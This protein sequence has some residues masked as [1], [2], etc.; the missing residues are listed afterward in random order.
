MGDVHTVRGLSILQ[1][2]Y[3]GKHIMA[4]S[5]SLRWVS[6]HGYTRKDGVKVRP[7][8][9]GIIRVYCFLKEKLARVK[10]G[11]SK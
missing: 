2:C 10:E 4:K 1:T 11:D 9:R 7:H 6:V 3:G 8:I 5:A